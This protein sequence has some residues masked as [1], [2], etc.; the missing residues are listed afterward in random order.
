MSNLTVFEFEQ[1]EIRFVGT[2]EKLEW[3]AA[4]IL[5]I[6]YPEADKRNH[7]NYLKKV[8]NKWKGHKKIMTPGGEQEVATLLEPGLYYLI[9]RSNS[10]VAE[11]FQDWLYED[12]IPTIRKTGKYELAP[13]PSPSPQPVLPPSLEQISDLVD[14]TLGKAGIDPRLVAGAKLNAI[15]KEYPS[16]KSAAEEAKSLLV[17]PVERNL[18]NAT[19][20]GDK[21]GKT[22]REVNKL[23]LD[24]GFQVKNP[25]GKNP[26]YLPTDK[27]KPHSQM[28]LD[29]AQGRDKTVQHLRWHETVIDALSEEINDKEAL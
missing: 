28:T 24:Q 21:I 2:P 7:S 13:S 4:D 1:K 27:G 29:T 19:Q 10:P 22:A 23:L 3:V 9:G 8:R 17:V 15:V 26:S 25:E 5:Y 14:L 12:V 11:P 16:L 6:L 18:L 20:I